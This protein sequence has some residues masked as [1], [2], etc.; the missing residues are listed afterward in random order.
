[1]KINIKILVL[2]LLL[3]SPDIFAQAEDEVIKKH[4]D[5][6]GG[7]ENWDKIKSLRM[8]HTLKAEGAE[9]KVVIAQIDK[10]A[11]RQDITV[12][13]M[14]GYS[15]VNNTEG[16]N[17]MPW[18][19]QTKPEAMTAE[20]VKST[21]DDLNLKDEFITYKDLGK[22][23]ESL[24]KD[25]VDGTE[26]FKYKMTDKDGAET[27]FYIDSENYHIIKQVDKK[28]VNGKEVEN[29]TTFSDYKKL[30][31]GITFPMSITGPWGTS[32]ITK[33]EINPAIDE[34]IFK[35]TN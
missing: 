12:M 26:C 27:T 34:S 23:L 11:M 22:K 6:I 13:G 8:E 1:M 17:Y 25:D 5:A 29:T 28:T 30:D 19:S 33:L 3:A 10:R 7:K 20:D 18:M 15:I 14:T 35:V 32:Q 2:F 24:G 4:I 16:W 9:I 21:Q 31:E